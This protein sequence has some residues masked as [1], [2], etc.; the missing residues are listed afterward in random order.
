MPRQK[1]TDPGIYQ[2]ETEAGKRWGAVCY[3]SPDPDTGR[4]RQKRKQGF[5][6]KRQAL[7]WRTANLH[8]RH[9]GTDITEPSRQPLRDWLTEWLAGLVDIAPGT[10]RNY[11][12]YLADVSAAIGATPLVEVTPI[13]LE[14]H[15]AA[16]L[17]QGDSRSSVRYSHRVLK[18]ALRKAFILGMIPAN[19]CER[20]KPPREEKHVPT[21]WTQEQ[22]QTFLSDHG[23]HPRWG[24]LWNVLAETW[25]RISEA[26][27]LRWS[28]IDFAERSITISHAITR[29]AD[30]QWISGKPKTESSNRTILVSAEL[31]A[32]FRQRKRTMGGTV[33]PSGL[34]FPSLFG[35]DFIRSASVHKVLTSACKASGL[36]ILSPHE[37]RHNGG[38][39]AYM[40]GV[41]IKTISERMGHANISI[42][43]QTYTHLNEAHHRAAADQIAALIRGK[44]DTNM[45][46]RQTETRN[47]A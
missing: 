4:S 1:N 45:T 8:S 46:S 38:S 44:C 10:R 26:L 5:E 19:P 14:R 32:M 43:L 31:I 18:Q 17:R 16:R 35:A 23:D 42:T 40:D 13:M 28:D 12:N 27:D 37:L 15:N 21:T 20:V 11:Q 47:V 25:L 7:Q 9:R 39:I 36:P 41:D 2:Y 3:A 33:I 29:D 6:T 34:I 24:L 22:M 30:L